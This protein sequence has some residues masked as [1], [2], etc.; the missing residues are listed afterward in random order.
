MWALIECDWDPYLKKKIGDRHARR[1]NTVWTQGRGWAVT[2]TSQRTPKIAANYPKP[3]ERRG[4]D[5]SLSPQKELTLLMPE[6]QTSGLQ[7]SKKADCCSLTP[8]VCDAL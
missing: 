6:C 8:P 4:T 1:E 2:S 7:S 3:R 5:A